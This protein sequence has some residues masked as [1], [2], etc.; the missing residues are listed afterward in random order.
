VN[1]ERE[2]CGAKWLQPSLRCC[3]DISLKELFVIAF[4]FVVYVMK[5]TLRK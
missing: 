1:S 4:M 2:E 3:F 5:M